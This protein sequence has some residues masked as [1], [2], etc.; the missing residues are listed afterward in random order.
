MLEPTL[1]LIALPQEQPRRPLGS[2]WTGALRW[3]GG[4]AAVPFAGA[5]L[6]AA[7]TGV[8]S[9]VGLAT[10]WLAPLDWLR[11]GYGL[12]A[13]AALTAAAVLLASFIEG[14]PARVV[15]L[16]RRRHP[17]NGEVRPIP[18]WLLEEGRFESV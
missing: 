11:S 3:N 10:G 12:I 17:L 6:W 14:M 8:A 4:V 18:G 5:A 16:A 9:L 7:A 15:R 2:A 13:A 1:S